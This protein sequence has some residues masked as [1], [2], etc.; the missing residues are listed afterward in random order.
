MM[1]L[2]LRRSPLPPGE[3]KPMTEEKLAKRRSPF[4]T[5]IAYHEPAR[6]AILSSRQSH[7]AY[8]WA[9]SFPSS[10]AGR[11]IAPDLIGMGTRT[12]GRTARVEGLAFAKRQ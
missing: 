7:L 11:L 1:R 8:L 10:R 5:N 6:T 12:N 3:I 9:M 4:G 2:A